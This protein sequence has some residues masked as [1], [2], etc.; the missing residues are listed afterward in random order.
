MKPTAKLIHVYLVP[1]A[2]LAVLFFALRWIPVQMTLAWFVPLAAEYV[3]ATIPPLQIVLFIGLTVGGLFAVAILTMTRYLHRRV[4]YRRRLRVLEDKRKRGHD[5]IA[6][7]VFDPSSIEIED[8]DQ[9][10]SA[11]RT[12]CALDEDPRLAML[13]STL[14]AKPEFQNFLQRLL[15]ADA[16][17]GKML[18]P[19]MR[20]ELAFLRNLYLDQSDVYTRSVST[21][22]SARQIPPNQDRRRVVACVALLMVLVLAPVP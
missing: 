12:F 2:I 1:L 3:P 21:I 16:G 14:W 10:P 6:A 15:K 19:E 8:D 9:Q 13:I 18:T 5:D 11:A 17:E 7:S 4:I 22:E 20:H